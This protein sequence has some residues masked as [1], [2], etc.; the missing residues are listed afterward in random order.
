REKA[1]SLDSPAARHVRGGAE[2]Q[3]KLPVPVIT[4]DPLCE[5]ATDVAG[6]SSASGSSVCSSPDDAPDHHVS[7]YAADRPMVM[8]YLRICCSLWS[9]L[10]CSPVQFSRLG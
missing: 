9:L 4:P 6:C 1:R 10:P 5:E 7:R 8:A 2:F 3:Y